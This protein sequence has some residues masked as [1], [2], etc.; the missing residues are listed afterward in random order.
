M[1]DSDAR[2]RRSALYL[3]ASNPRAIDKA[4]SLPADVVIFDL[5]DAVA[6]G[7]KEQAREN[8]AQAFGQ[9][10]FGGASW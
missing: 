3:P 4:R 2:P 9:G 6:P 8:L 7:A 10:G 5:E 1:P